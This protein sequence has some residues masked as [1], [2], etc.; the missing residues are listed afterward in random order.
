MKKKQR[1][2]GNNFISSGD[3]AFFLYHQLQCRVSPQRILILNSGKDIFKKNDV[4]SVPANVVY[5]MIRIAQLNSR[6]R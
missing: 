6:M 3:F 5:D 2:K 1:R 4:T